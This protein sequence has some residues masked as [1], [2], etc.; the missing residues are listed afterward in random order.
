VCPVGI[1]IIEVINRLRGVEH[2]R[3]E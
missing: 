1:D 2:A 3:V